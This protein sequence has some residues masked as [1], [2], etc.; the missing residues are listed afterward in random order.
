MNCPQCQGE[1]W[2]NRARIRDEGWKG[3]VYKCKDQNCGWVQWPAKKTAPAQKVEGG[4]GMPT[5]TARSGGPKHTWP[6]L[7]QMYFQALIIARKQVIGLGAATKLGVRMEDI[8]SAAATIFIAASRD[9]VKQPE[10]EPE[11][12]EVE[13]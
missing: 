11:P 13:A 10:P 4:P 9:G 7:S 6:G 12:E 3:P 5:Q 8:L 1:V 2:D